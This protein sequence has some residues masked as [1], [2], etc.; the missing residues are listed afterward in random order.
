[1]IY[2]V[3]GNGWSL[4]WADNG[5]GIRLAGTGG[6]YN[7]YHN[8]VSLSVNQAN[9][10]NTAAIAVFNTGG[11]NDLRN[12]IFAN[13]Q[14]NGTRVAIYT[15]Q[16]SSIFGTIN[17][18]N[19][20]SA[21]HVGVNGTTNR[22]TLANWVTFSGQDANSFAQNPQFVSA[23]DLHIQACQGLAGT[24]IAAI[25]TDIDG[26][27]RIVPIIG[28]DEVD[29][30]PAA[31]GLITGVIQPCALVENQPYS[32]APVT[33]A[34]S[35]NWTLPTGWSIASGSG[36][37]AITVNTGSAGQNGNIEVTASNSCTSAPQTLAVTLPAAN[38]VLSGDQSNRECLVHKDGWVH[39]YDQDGDLIAS[40][41]SL[42]QNL[43]NVQATS[44]VVSTPYVTEA[45]D[46][47]TNPSFFQTTL[48]R[49]FLIDADNPPTDTV[50]VRLYIL[51]AEVTNY[52]T[53]AADDTPQNLQDN[54]SGISELHLTKVSSGSGTGD[55]SDICLGGGSPIYIN[56]SASGDINGIGFSGFSST[57][58]LEF[59]ITGFSEFFPMSSGNF[60]SALPVELT[61]FGVHCLGDEVKISWTTASEL[62]AS[63]YILENSRDGYNWNEV[64][65]IEANGTTNQISNYTHVAK[66]FGG[67]SYFR[68]VQVDLD[69]VTEIFGPIS[70]NC[71]N[72]NNNMTVFPNP[73][74][75]NFIVRIETT[76]F[77]ENATLELVDM[78]G[79]VVKSQSS[80]LNTGTTFLNFDGANLQPGAY[81][82]RVK[83]ENDNFTP[84]R[85]VKM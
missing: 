10:G 85:V 65:Q 6:G 44:F 55:P 29:I 18:N 11:V 69:G 13:T 80:D 46:D 9:A 33:G 16:P 19:Y 77:F 35:Y 34:T 64:A 32:V 83:G 59:K 70:S 74:A 27:A 61:S 22:T 81:M 75:D 54:I 42:G 21:Q 63:H 52:Q 31:P 39:F 78:T 17:F 56:Q 7:I 20:F 3:T 26:D 40:V 58:Y 71:E 72:E 82:V 66:N 48:Q 41:N 24:T 43:G 53:T 8:T 30:A 36:T 57:G 60:N 50:L 37:N 1:M 14:T 28:A 68:L 38:T 79:R 47:P 76:Q 84:I 4:N 62:N 2:N 73:T 51:D 67:L 49:T 12:N 15:N 45:C 5:H 23:T 25:T